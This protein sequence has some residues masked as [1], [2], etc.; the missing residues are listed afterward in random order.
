M[1]FLDVFDL[2]HVILFWILFHCN[3]LRINS[4]QRVLER[5]V[6]DRNSHLIG[7]VHKG[8][9]VI[10]GDVWC[11]TLDLG[12]KLLRLTR[13]YFPKGVWITTISCCILK[14]Y[15]ITVLLRKWRLLSCVIKSYRG[16][17][18]LNKLLRLPTKSLRV[19]IKE[20]EKVFVY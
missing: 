12:N 15:H 14:V 20:T 7:I 17:I 13:R 8:I 2:I 6:I 11:V 16:T 4:Y 18:L 5:I 3:L 1:F 19:H 9:I 10:V